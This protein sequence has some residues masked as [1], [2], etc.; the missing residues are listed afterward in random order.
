MM[1]AKG[2]KQTL[3]AFAIRK[4]CGDQQAPDNFFVIALPAGCDLSISPPLAA[5][6]AAL[7]RSHPELMEDLQWHTAAIAAF[8]QK[9]S[10]LPE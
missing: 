6:A 4:R 3:G 9:V 2:G 8:L 7:L 5:Q 10:Q 1:A